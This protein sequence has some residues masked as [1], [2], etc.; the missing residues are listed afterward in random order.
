M[1]EWT[2]RRP[3]GS[4]RRRRPAAERWD[5]LLTIGIGGAIGSSA[6]YGLSVLLPYRAG[7]LPLP[8][9]LANVLGCLLIGALMAAITE[10]TSPHRLLR[11]FLGVGILGGFTT[12]STYVVDVVDTGK[13]GH[14]W[15]AVLYGSG[16]VV[17]CILAVVAGLAVTRLALRPRLI[18]AGGT[19]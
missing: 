1:P 8:T 11:P 18:R 6:R 5:V 14:Q 19:P 7:E 17:G 15:V 9:L 12:F 10:A 16:T 13:A 3:R 4:G 2:V